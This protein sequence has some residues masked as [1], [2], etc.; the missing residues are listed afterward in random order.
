MA[1]GSQASD[2]ACAGAERRFLRSGAG[3]RVHVGPEPQGVAYVDTEVFQPDCA[4]YAFVA[5]GQAFP[6]STGRV[7]FALFVESL[8][9]VLRQASLRNEA[10]LTSRFPYQTRSWL[11]SER[12]KSATR[13]APDSPVT[14]TANT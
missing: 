10:R 11:N 12:R 7:S 3:E 1:A 8:P 14:R 13:T 5:A 4:A 6:T 2:E 9:L